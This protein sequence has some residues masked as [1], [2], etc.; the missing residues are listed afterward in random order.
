[1]PLP[2]IRAF[3]LSLSVASAV[4]AP[5]FGSEPVFDHQGEVRAGFNA[6]LSRVVAGTM[7]V[8][9]VRG[10]C[11]ASAARWRGTSGRRHRIRYADQTDLFDADVRAHIGSLEPIR[12]RVSDTSEV[13]E[14]IFRAAEDAPSLSLVDHGTPQNLHCVF[15]GLSVKPL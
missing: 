14:E 13:T 9:S 6:R 1:M 15:E 8:L 5:A 4:A 7:Y 10:H 11:Q 12:L 3:A 2:R